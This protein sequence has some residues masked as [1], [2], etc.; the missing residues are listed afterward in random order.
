[1]NSWFGHI[2]KKIKKVYNQSDNENFLKETDFL[3][4]V[5]FDRPITVPIVRLLQKSGLKIHPNYISLSSFP[6]IL[7]AGLFFFN[8]ELIVGAVFYLV[9]FIIDGIDGKWARLTCQA[10]KLG[11]RLDYFIAIIGGFVAYFGLWHSQFYCNGIPLIGAIII[12]GHYVAIAFYGTLLEN[13][14]YN[15]GVPVV[16][17]YYTPEEEAFFTFFIAAIFNVVT[18]AIPVLVFLQVVSFLTLFIIQRQRP[19]V[20]KIRENITKRLLKL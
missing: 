2:I 1:M 18:V 14:F 15:T 19:S 6:F 11:E 9:Y 3:V 16:G 5:L 17:S 8:N 4:S 13:P 12:V 7:L 10:S 20:G